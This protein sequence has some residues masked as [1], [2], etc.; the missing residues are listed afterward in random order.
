MMP[1]KLVNSPSPSSCHSPTQLQPTPYPASAPAQ[2]RCSPGA[3]QA[4]RRRNPGAAQPSP[5]QPQSSPSPAAVQK[6]YLKITTKFDAAA[7]ISLTI[8][9]PSGRRSLVSNQTRN[10]Q[11]KLIIYTVCRSNKINR[12]KS[13]FICLRLFEY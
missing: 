5:I 7:I 4:Q 13:F 6:M 8:K 11:T 9:C 10:K 3:A 1:L 12:L 2:P